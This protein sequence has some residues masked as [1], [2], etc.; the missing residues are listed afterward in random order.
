MRQER[1]LTRAEIMKGNDMN[2]NNGKLR[3]GIVGLGRVATATHIPVLKQLEDIEITACAEMNQDRISRVKQFFQIPNL[4]A[5]YREMYDSGLVDAVYICTP[6]HVHFDSV[7]AA[8]ERGIHVLCEKPMGR[9]LDEAVGMTTLA[10]ERN[11]VLMPG[12]KYRYNANLQQ[13]AGIVR[14]GKLGG[15]LQVEATFMTPGPYISWDPK[16]DW[17]L[18]KEQGG[19]IYDIGVH[20][21]ELLHLLVPNEIVSVAAY[22]DA[23]Y[24]EYDTPTNVACSFSMDSG[25]TGTVVFGWRSSVDMTKVAIYGTG[26]AISVSLKSFDYFNAG[27]DPKDRIITHLKN[28]L[29]EARTVTNRILS[30]IK[31]KEVSLNDL[32]QAR[33]FVAAITR[34]ATPPVSGENAVYVHR[35]L[36]GIRES[37]DRGCPIVL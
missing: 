33:A 23:G 16:S 22:A 9:N 18:E 28:S 12:F 6:P 37:I 31:G 4:F 15:V 30:I 26:G 13:A 21:I 17:Y 5:D 32:Q 19:V 1:G 25:V 3:I 14:S 7:T 11:L 8:L 24:H 20:I 29:T 27:T 34:H 36:K 10:N 35:V 2:H